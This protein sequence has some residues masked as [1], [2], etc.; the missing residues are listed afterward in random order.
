MQLSFDP[1]T[2]LPVNLPA[3]LPTWATQMPV[4]GL[5]AQGTYDLATLWREQQLVQQLRA[6]L[7]QQGAPGF[8]LDHL[9][10]IADV[11]GALVVPY[12]DKIASLDELP[13]EPKAAVLAPDLS[14]LPVKWQP[15]DPAIEVASETVDAFDVVASRPDV[16]VSVWGG[17][18]EIPYQRSGVAVEIVDFDE[19]GMTEGQGKINNLLAGVNDENDWL[20]DYPLKE[21]EAEE[22]SDKSC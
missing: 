11:L 10:T 1:E 9:A 15:N 3:E 4:A 22:G 2:L 20:P 6:T 13:T 18:V 19:V 17:V 12:A 14:P 5:S 21:D 16:I 8:L 7:A